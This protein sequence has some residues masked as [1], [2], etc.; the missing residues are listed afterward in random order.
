MSSKR[1][2]YF[3]T[4]LGF[5]LALL[6]PEKKTLDRIQRSVSKRDGQLEEITREQ[7]AERG[8]TTTLNQ[9]DPYDPD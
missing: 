3:D 8:F 5:G 2:R 1:K 4:G 7:F 9:S 6:D